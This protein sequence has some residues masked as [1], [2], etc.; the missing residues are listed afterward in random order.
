MHGRIGEDSVAGAA[1]AAAEGL[2]GDRAP[3]AEKLLK[4][5]MRGA[6]Q[7]EGARGAAAALAPVRTLKV[8]LPPALPRDCP[9]LGLHKA[10]PVAGRRHW[11]VVGPNRYKQEISAV[12]KF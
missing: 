5:P 7:G 2:D 4:G 10:L 9:G 1:A 8:L 11:S 12:V 3:K 6:A